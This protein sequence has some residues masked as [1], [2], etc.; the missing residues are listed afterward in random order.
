[1]A[2]WMVP[3]AMLL[4]SLSLLFRRQALLAGIVLGIGIATKTHLLAVVPFYFIYFLANRYS[5]KQV[6]G[7]VG[8]SLLVAGLCMVLLW[9]DGFMQSVFGTAEAAKIIWFT[10]R[11]L[12]TI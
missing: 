2:S 11:F 6:V 5:T 4:I 10:Y 8:T 3:T 12:S 1:M 9:S 7:Y